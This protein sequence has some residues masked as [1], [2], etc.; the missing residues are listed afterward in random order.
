LQFTLSRASFQCSHYIL[1]EIFWSLNIIQEKIGLVLGCLTIESKMIFQTF[2]NVAVLLA[3]TGRSAE[4]R[5]RSR[6]HSHS[7]S[8]LLPARKPAGNEEA[9]DVR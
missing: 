5:N 9:T 7:C 1:H 6:S 4:E 2:D 3:D 8:C